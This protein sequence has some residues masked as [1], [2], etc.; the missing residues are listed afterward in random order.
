M[1]GSTASNPQGHFGA[2][3][4]NKLAPVFET[5]QRSGQ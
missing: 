3:L 5:M 2:A 4:V 1:D